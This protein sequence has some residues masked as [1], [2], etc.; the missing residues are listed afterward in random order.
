MS[1]PALEEIIWFIGIVPQDFFG[2][3]LVREKHWLFTENN[4]FHSLFNVFDELDRPLHSNRKLRINLNLRIP[5]FV[6]RNKKEWKTNKQKV[7]DWRLFL[8][9]TN[10]SSFIWKDRIKTCIKFY[11][12]EN[13][14]T[15]HLITHYK[16]KL[17]S[18]C[19][20]MMQKIRLS[21]RL[22]LVFWAKKQN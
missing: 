20:S 10:F 21:S 9:T 3:S 12:K 16:F 15:S 18:K 2:Y 1:L 11:S 22:S 19:C 6:F 8:K 4:F 13:D 17:F 5:F 7:T 14:Q